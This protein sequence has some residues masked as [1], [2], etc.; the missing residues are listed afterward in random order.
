[1]LL[2]CALAWTGHRAMH[3]AMAETHTLARRALKSIE[4]LRW[5]M[6]IFFQ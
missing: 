4:V 3:K 2:D 5:D 6:W 1:M